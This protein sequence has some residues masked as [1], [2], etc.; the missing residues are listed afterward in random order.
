[1][2]R[3]GDIVIGVYNDI[4]QKP[5][6]YLAFWRDR[7]RLVIGFNSDGLWLGLAKVASGFEVTVRE[8]VATDAA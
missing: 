6:S 1:M 7:L 5:F 4:A 8:T 2:N 3:T